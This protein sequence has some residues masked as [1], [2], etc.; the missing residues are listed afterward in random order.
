MARPS[1]LAV[2]PRTL[3]LT[4]LRKSKVPMSAYDLLAKLRARGVK[5]PPTVYRALQSLQAEGLIHRIESL[6][7]FI[8]CHSEEADHGTQFAVCRDCKTVV[9]LHDHRICKTIDQLGKS[10]GFRVEREMLELIGLCSHCDRKT[11]AA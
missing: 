7:A 11:A 8:A 3:I 1:S 6:G 10:I 2:H 9:E 4:A 5:A